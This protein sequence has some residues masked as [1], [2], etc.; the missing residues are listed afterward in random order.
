MHRLLPTLVSLAIACG[1]AQRWD[2]EG[3]V[4]EVQADYDQVVIAHEDIPGL[5]PAM[6]MN[7]DVADPALLERLAPGQQIDFVLE[8]DGRSY[9]VV[10][11]EI[12]KGELGAVGAG[13]RIAN[14]ARAASPAPEF[15]L[16]DQD[17]EELS[18]SDLRGKTLLVDFVYTHCPGPCPI[19]TGTHVAAQES[20]PEALRE[21]IRFV[22]I[23]L[24][25]ER[26]TPQALRAYAEARG[27]DLSSWSFLTGDP[28]AVDA[29]LS[30]YGVGRTRVEGGEIDHIVATF[31]I[32]GE[33]RIVKR[34]IGLDHEPETLAGDLRALAQLP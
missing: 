6:T 11:A 24:D 12:R 26:D 31:L 7:F 30:A 20:L 29:V 2:A 28:E 14:L 23:S 16:V 22:S 15:R 32:D 34:Y 5:M 17:G 19:L 18:L 9:R 27:A 1:G 3:V 25:P 10:E 8:Y 21:R 13:A 33:G 4:E